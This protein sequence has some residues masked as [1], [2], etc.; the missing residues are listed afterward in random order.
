MLSKTLC[1]NRTLFRKNLT[2][3]WPLW[4]MASFGGSL[5]PLAMLLELLRNPHWMITKLEVTAAYYEVLCYGVPLISLFYAILC[6]VAVWSY[7]Y[8]GRHV[9]M[10]HTL[11]IRR[12]GLFFT[13]FLSGMVMMMIPYVVVGALCVLITLACGAFAPVSLLVT[14]LGVLGESFFYF[15]TA[16]AVAFITGN[17]FALPLLYFLLHFLAVILEWLISIFSAAFIFGLSGNYSG[18]VEFFSPTVYLMNLVDADRVYEETF[19]RDLIH[20][21]VTPDGFGYYES[22][23]VA[24]NLENGWLILVY[25]LLGVVCVAIAWAL[26]QRRRSETAGDVVS[27]GW[28]KPLFRY[29]GAA[30]AA[31]LGGWALYELFWNSFRYDQYCQPIPMTICMLI[32]G[33]IGYYAA[34]MLLAKSFRVFR[35]SWKGVGLVAMGCAVMCCVLHFDLLG[36][37]ARV[38]ELDKVEQVSIQ[39]ANNSYELYPEEDAALIEEIRAVHQAIL[40]DE[41][42]IKN[43]ENVYDDYE[44]ER[45]EI[46]YDN[47]IRLDYY[48]KDGRTVQRRYDVPM[49]RTRMMQSDTYDAMLDALVNGQMM[50]EERIHLNDPKF[51]IYQGAMYIESTHESIDLNTQEAAAILEAVGKDAREGTWGNYDWF[52]TDTG[53]RYAIDLS[54]AFQEPTENNS[55]G[56]Y[57]DH[58]SIILRP[59]MTHTIACLRQL[60]LVAPEHFKT[61]A[62][63]YPEDY[64]D[65]YQEFRDKFGM[66]YEEYVEIYG[67]TSVTYTTP[68]LA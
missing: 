15:S 55:R 39:V 18:V 47:Y 53:G 5:F 46:S 64:Q 58:L 31:M 59:E 40:A 28:M 51:T 42:Y 29:G 45:W 8:N 23:L 33:T 52:H 68:A 13:N 65:E 16:T 37:A 48:L 6:A 54:L 35:G 10:M 38:P 62:E 66:S 3:F 32:A 26:Y 41:E 12:E 19:V 44:T 61:Y 14:I 20:G 56:Y 34:S 22:E 4:G 63:L 27:V 25:A 11:P 21:S 50:K 1:F 57:L 2:R 24:V 17:V 60:G 36:V 49:T 9:G 30:L 7:L 67:V 43:T